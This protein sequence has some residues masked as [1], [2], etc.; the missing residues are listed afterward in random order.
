M[1]LLAFPSARRTGWQPGACCVLSIR[2]GRLIPPK[3]VEASLPTS[4]EARRTTLPSRP[5][6]VV[7]GDG[8][9]LDGLK[10]PCANRNASCVVRVSPGGQPSY[11]GSKDSITRRFEGALP[12]ESGNAFQA[13]DTREPARVEGQGRDRDCEAAKDDRRRRKLDTVPLSVHLLTFH[14]SFGDAH[15]QPTPI[16]AT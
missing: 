1:P 12:P 13:H 7:A 9:R 5:Q 6:G 15:A 14:D 8:T 4:L 2:L 16:Y 10:D 11:A 3:A